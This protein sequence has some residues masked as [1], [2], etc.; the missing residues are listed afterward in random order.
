MALAAAL[1]TPAGPASAQAGSGPVLEPDVEQQEVTDGG[2]RLVGQLVV[3]GTLDVEIAAPFDIA[4]PVSVTWTTAGGTVLSQDLTWVLPASVYGQV[5]TA[6]VTGTSVDGEVLVV[7]ATTSGPVGAGAFVV[8]PTPTVA[9]T[10]RVGQTLTAAAGRWEPEAA[11]TVRWLRDGTPISGATGST[12]TLVAADRGT[13]VSVEVRGALDGYV[14]QTRTSDGRQ[15]QAG[16]FSTAPTP[17]LS[18]AV[19]VG[20]TVK[21]RPGS[22]SPSATFTYQW[23]RNGT[24]IKGATSSS[25]RPVVADL[26]KKLTVRVTAKRSGFTTLTRTSAAATVGRGTLSAPTPTVRGTAQVGSTLT[27]VPGT[28]SPSAKRTYQ[29]KRDGKAIKGATKSTYRVVEADRGK[30]LSVTVKGTRDGYTTASKTS[31]ATAKVTRAFTKAPAPKVTGTA[32]V[33]STLKASTAA[34]SPAATLSYQWKRDGKAI[35]GATRSSYKL[36]G[37]DYNAKITVTVTGKRSGFTT[38]SRTS[39][40]TAKV[41][42]PAAVISRDGTHRVG[43]ALPAGTYMSS[44]TTG[45]CYWERRTN[46]G[47]SS[48]GVITNG[49]G[50]GRQI[51]RVSATDRYFYT[52]DCGSWTRLTALGEPRS[53]MGDGIHAV[54]VHIRPGVYEAYSSSEPC[55]WA[56]LSG[57]NGTMGD[58]I[59]YDITEEPYR[60]RVRVRA[61]DKGFDTIGC[62]TWRRVSS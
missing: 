49:W 33:G 46:S 17:T 28:W 39:S 12:Y 4:A 48:S 56:R 61:S 35:S 38:R 29:W 8:A 2:V 26:G 36:T 41:K 23:R 7:S 52:Q 54:G 57:F 25:Y 43:A 6:T 59:E 30:R 50:F 55:F 11:V 32:R 24:P 45:L 18:G 3:G 31:K 47:S 14:T 15:V 20:S 10:W 53:S 34:W 51:V 27:A 21:A 62:G 40:A 42:R 60:H 22:W 37:A 1:M 5:V 9:G 16:T 19:R 44:G 13:T 58:I